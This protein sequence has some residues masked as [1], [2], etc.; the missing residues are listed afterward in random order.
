MLTQSD[1]GAGNPGSVTLSYQ[2]T[3]LDRICSIAYGTAAPATVCNVKYD[4]VGNMIEKPSRTGG[5]RTLTYF[6]SG[7]VKTIVT[8]G[9]NATFDYDAFGAVQRL[10]L[11]STS[12]QTRATTSTSAA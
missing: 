9:T 8:R 3:D 1:A 12:S 2:T 6:P 4:G 10:V 11:T 5:T 7:Q